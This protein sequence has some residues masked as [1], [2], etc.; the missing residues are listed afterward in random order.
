M[1]GK[2]EETRMLLIDTLETKH[3]YK[4]VDPFSPE[5]S[6]FATETLKNKN[7]GNS[8]SQKKKKANTAAY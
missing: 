3:P 5:A 6:Q 8:S 4:S 2:Q 7:V 1:N